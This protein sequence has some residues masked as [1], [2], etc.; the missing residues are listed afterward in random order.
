MNICEKK[1]FSVVDIYN[2]I[3]KKKGFKKKSLKSI[4]KHLKND[5][6]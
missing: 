5:N 1:Y 6:A 4:S 3:F 2:Q